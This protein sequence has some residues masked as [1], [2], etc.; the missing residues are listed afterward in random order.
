M[1]DAI[2]M[3]STHSNSRNYSAG[4]FEGLSKMGTVLKDGV[5]LSCHRDR[6]VASTPAMA[7]AAAKNIAK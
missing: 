3:P 1:Q 7:A 6:R 5:P 2:G 4:V